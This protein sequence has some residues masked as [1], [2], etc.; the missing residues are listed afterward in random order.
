LVSAAVFGFFAALHGR[1]CP[2][3]GILLFIPLTFGALAGHA[4]GTL[5]HP[6]AHDEDEE[7]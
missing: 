1:Q 7:E 4:I 6:S 2:L 5:R 3:I